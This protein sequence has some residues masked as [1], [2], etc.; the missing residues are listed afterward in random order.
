[1]AARRFTELLLDDWYGSDHMRF[2]RAIDPTHEDNKE[3]GNVVQFGI[4]P[5]PEYNKNFRW[6]FFKD[7]ISRFSNA[8][9][10]VS[11]VQHVHKHSRSSIV[12]INRANNRKLDG[13]RIPPFAKVISGMEVVD[14]IYSGYG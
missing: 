7:E 3:K 4:H 1:M 13:D 11:M 14:M 12:M 2:Y 5:D 9:G 6:D 10:M 8:R